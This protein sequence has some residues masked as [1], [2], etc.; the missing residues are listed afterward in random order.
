MRWISAILGFFYE[1]LLGCRHNKLTRP[2]T[3]E[4]QTYK[5][6]LDCGRQVFYSAESMRPLSSGEIRR[7]QLANAGANN[8]VPL[9]ARVR[10]L[11]TPSS[12]SRAA[13]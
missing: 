2:F 5:V 8:V 11:A 6:C 9:T 3:L 1:I 7:M 4:Q 13:A 12:K 10:E